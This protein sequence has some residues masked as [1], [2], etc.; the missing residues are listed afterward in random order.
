MIKKKLTQCPRSPLPRHSFE[1]TTPVQKSRLYVFHVKEF[2]LKYKV[3][4]LGICTLEIHDCTLSF[5]NQQPGQ[6]ISNMNSR[7]P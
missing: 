3:A 1:R 6:L 7:Y 4:V 2:T 5:V